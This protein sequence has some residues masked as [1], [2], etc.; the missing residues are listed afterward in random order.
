MTKRWN[1]WTVEANPNRQDPSAD[2]VRVELTGPDGHRYLILL[3]EAPWRMSDE[4]IETLD[5][6]EELVYDELS[7]ARLL[8]TWRLREWRGD[9]E[10]ETRI[11]WSSVSV[12]RWEEP[13]GTQ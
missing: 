8:P 1:G 7:A 4:P 5:G 9:D 10:D 12:G 6:F 3:S 11:A 2:G 13:D